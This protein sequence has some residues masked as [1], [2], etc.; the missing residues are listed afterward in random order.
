M[1]SLF[2]ENMIRQ[3]TRDESLRLK[4]YLCQA[5]KHTIGIVTAVG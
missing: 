1:M 3:L 5:G 2:K 4:P